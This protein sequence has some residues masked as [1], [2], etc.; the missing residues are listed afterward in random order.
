MVKYSVAV[1]IWVSLFVGMTSTSPLIG[2]GGKYV[3]VEPTESYHWKGIPFKGGERA[4][5]IVVG[6]HD[7]VC[8][9]LIEVFDENNNSVVKA[10]PGSDF[11]AAIWYP[12]RDG[13]FNIK[14]SLRSD[15]WNKC[16]VSIK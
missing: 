12:K 10:D 8:D 2:R 16:W 3:K 5:V 4:C 13:I 6:D 9:I 11:C 1:L 7:P 14:V 15:V